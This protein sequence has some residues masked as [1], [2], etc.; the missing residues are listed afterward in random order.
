VR[1]HVA[2]IDFHVTR[3][4]T[5]SPEALFDTL[6]DHASYKDMTPLRMSVLE[7]PGDTDPNGVGARRR[8]G[9]VGP[10]QV[11]E[12]TVFERPTRFAYRLVSGLPVR[13]HVGTVELTAVPGG[14][15]IDYHV[16]STP[17]VPGLGL[18]LGPVL[19]QGITGLLGGV[20]KAAEG[21]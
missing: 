13:D 9:V 8:I 4:S 2:V 12:V 14:T 3:T 5:A 18:V 6:T 21:R 1:H 7:R 10:T 20:V 19:K 16:R 15:R 11:E 17:T